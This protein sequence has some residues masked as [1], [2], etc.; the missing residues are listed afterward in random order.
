[1]TTP[2]KIVIEEAVKHDSKGRVCLIGP[3]GS[4]KSLTMLRLARLLAG[5]EGKILMVDTEQGSLAKYAVTKKNPIPDNVYTF[6]FD[7]IKLKEFSLDHWQACH[8]AAIDGGYAVFGTDSLSHFWVGKDGAL[9][10]V[11]ER[12]RQANARRGDGQDGWKQF[13]PHERAMVD[14]MTS[15]PLHIIC[16]MRTKN[17]YVDVTDERGRK[18]RQKIGLAPVQRDGLEYEFDLVGY[19]TD[20]N[21][22]VT[23]KT[24]CHHYARKAIATPTAEDF[25]PFAEWLMGDK[26]E[27]RAAPVAEITVQRSEDAAKDRKSGRPTPAPAFESA[28]AEKPWQ[29]FGQM[30]QVFAELKAQIPAGDYEYILRAHGVDSPD[31]FKSTDE[32]LKCWAAMRAYVD[33]TKGDKAA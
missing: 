2:I 14:T 17:E 23:D 8:A 9:E 30:R 22:F 21:E 7:V 31:K 13:R 12:Q 26:L 10:F 6:K 29:N 4:G 1:M 20:E 19:M 27:D 28:A 32:A 5:P 16:T 11:D 15:S 33:K 18:K 3:G 24:R 25:L